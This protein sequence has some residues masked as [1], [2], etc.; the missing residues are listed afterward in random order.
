MAYGRRV[1]L[2]PKRLLA[3]LWVAPAL[4]AAA[5]LRA[6]ALVAY[7]PAVLTLQAHDG[8]GYIKAARLG[9]SN[10]VLEPLGYPLFLRLLHAISHQLAFTIAVQHALGLL[11]GLLLFLAVRRLAAPVWV[12]LVPAVVV[13][14]GADQLFLEHAPMSEGLFTPL[15]VATVYAGVRSLTGHPRW[16]AATGFLAASL[17]MVRTVATIAPL[18]VLVWLALAMW[19]VRIPCRAPAAAA[20]AAAV[21]LLGA[22]ALVWHGATGTWRVTPEGSGW[23]LYARASQF[24]DCHDFTPPARTRALCQ[25]IPP[26]QRPAPD[27]YHWIGGPA[28]TGFGPPPSQD[29]LIGA[30]ARQAILNQPFSYLTLVGVDL[31][32]YVDPSFELSRYNR[33][34]SPASLAFPGGTVVLDADTVRQATAYYGPLHEPTHAPA[35]RLSQYQRVFR[36]N[37]VMLLVLLLLG[38]VGVASSTGR[39]RWAL[40]LMLALAL[41]LLLVPALVQASWRYVVPTEGL[42][43]AAA[44]FGVWSMGQRVSA[45]RTAPR[46]S[47]HAG[48]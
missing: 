13:W 47:P 42:I 28:Y 1:L 19:R 39:A 4:A 40:L 48:P 25:S 18:I 22:Y 2:P 9:L 3:V 32:R 45:A 35:Y 34:A 29:G 5:A 46:P 30:F 8:A 12:A 17:L 37:G 36:V 21:A 11:A 10:D 31:V 27:Y 15:L 26:R 23:N 44:A 41:E 20:V 38:L 14:F 24:A 6:Y 7:P 43:A 16:A 33:T